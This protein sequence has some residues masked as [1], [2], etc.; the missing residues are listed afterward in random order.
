MQKIKMTR[1]QNRIY[2]IEVQA[3]YVGGRRLPYSHS[4]RNI[5]PS[6]PLALLLPLTTPKTASPTHELL[7]ACCTFLFILSCSTAFKIITHLWPLLVLRTNPPS[8]HKSI[9]LDWSQRTLIS[10]I[11]WGSCVFCL[12]LLSCV[13]SSFLNGWIHSV[14][15]H[16]VSEGVS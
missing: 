1:P 16:S 8:W 15:S 6:L 13:N 14:F 3:L 4:Q 10:L 12:L 5:L 2:S 7:S 11:R 9:Q